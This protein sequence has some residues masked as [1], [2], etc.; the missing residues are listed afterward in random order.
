MLYSL[1]VQEVHERP[2]HTVCILSHRGPCVG[3]R[4]PW[5]PH[6]AQDVSHL[7][8]ALI[9]P[10]LETTRVPPVWPSS[11]PRHTGPK[12]LQLLGPTRAHTWCS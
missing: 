10:H 3:G 4:V 12:R 1:A 11:T 9:N 8:H 7:S 5:A 2:E 6:L